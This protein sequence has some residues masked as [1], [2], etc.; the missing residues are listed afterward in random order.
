MVQDTFNFIPL[1][2]V[3]IRISLTDKLD[4]PQ[5]ITSFV[6]LLRHKH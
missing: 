2:L 3:A 5:N 1:I 4:K 6:T